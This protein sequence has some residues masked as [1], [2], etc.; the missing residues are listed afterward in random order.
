VG[1][2]RHLHR[3]AERS[4]DVQHAQSGLSGPAYPG[5][6]DTPDKRAAFDAF[7]TEPDQAKRVAIWKRLQALFY[8]EVPTIKIGSF[9]ALF[10]ISTRLSGYTPVADPAFWNVKI[11]G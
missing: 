3:R 9:Y 1:G 7:V 10:G 4:G 2:F 8:S 5:W 11:T 6:W